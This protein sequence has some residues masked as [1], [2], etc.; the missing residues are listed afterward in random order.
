[1]LKENNIDK[2]IVISKSQKT[3]K[4]YNIVRVKKI[5]C[6]LIYVCSL[7]IIGEVE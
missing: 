2:F 5:R 1:M 7:L 3:G 4:I 6:F